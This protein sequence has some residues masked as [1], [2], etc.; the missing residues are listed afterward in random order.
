MMRM[1]SRPARKLAPLISLPGSDFTEGPDVDLIDALGIDALADEVANLA[2][3]PRHPS[4]EVSP[5]FLHAPDGTAVPIRPVARATVTV[6]PNPPKGEFRLGLTAEQPKGWSLFQFEDPTRGSMPLLRVERSDGKPIAPG[7]M[8]WTAPK[9]AQGR[10]RFMIHLMDH[11]GT[12]SYQLVY[13]AQVDPAA[14]APRIDPLLP[15]KS[16]PKAPARPVRARMTWHALDESDE[17]VRYG[18]RGLASHRVRVT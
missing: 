6:V 2:A 12:G 15:L 16:K 1:E 17:A 10:N 4:F 9:D 13:A 3:E 8:L 7:P 5:D 14:E 11:N 18:T